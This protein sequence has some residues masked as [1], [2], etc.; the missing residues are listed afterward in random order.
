MKQIV[1]IVTIAV[2]ALL[3]LAACSREE[4]VN[5]GTDLPIRVEAGIGAPT[6]TATDGD[7]EVFTAGDQVALFVW[8][9]SNSTVPAE[10]VV[11]GIVNTLQQDGTWTPA[12]KMF[13]KD[14]ESAHYFLGVFPARAI[15]NFKMDSF[16]INPS[17]YTANDLLVATKL[18]GLKAT[19]VPV[20]LSFRHVMSKFQLNLSYSSQWDAVPAGTT[21]TATN[22]DT[23][24]KVD[25][26]NGSTEQASD[27]GDIAL[28]KLATAASGCAE[29]YSAILIPQAGFCTVTVVVGQQTFVYTHPSDIVLSSGKTTVLN[30]TVGRDKIELASDITLADWTVRNPLNGEAQDE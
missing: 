6:R 16:T 30:L 11:N 27:K 9:G 29:S 23:A 2:V 3:A 20:P 18:E 15:S 24:C 8:T 25:Y 28:T 19:E 1:S 22:V 14:A 5:P 12:T 4:P 7:A 10:R 21:V 26:L 17:D 13:W